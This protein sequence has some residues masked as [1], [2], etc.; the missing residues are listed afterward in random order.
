D[1]LA[2]EELTRPG[3]TGE[4]GS[5]EADAGDAW[6]DERGLADWEA[7]VLHFSPGAEALIDRIL[8]DDA[9]EPADPAGPA[10]GAPTAADLLSQLSDDDFWMACRFE[11]RR[12]AWM[13]WEPLALPA[14][15][16]RA[17]A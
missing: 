5:L 12:L 7:P 13:A 8:G 3:W 2:E 4:D 1:V 11:L 15:T 14:W 17:A 9:E 6:A 16:G 10:R